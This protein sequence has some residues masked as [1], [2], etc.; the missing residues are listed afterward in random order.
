ML[1]ANVLLQIT[2]LYFLAR[3][4]RGGRRLRGARRWS[5]SACCRSWRRSTSSSRST[6][7][8]RPSWCGAA[9]AAPSRSCW[10]WWRPATTSC[11]RTPASSSRCRPR[12]SCCSRCSSTQR[13]SACSC[14]CWASTSCRGWSSPCA[15]A[16]WRCRRSTSTAIWRRSSAG[17]TPASKASP[18]TRPRPARPR[19]RRCRP[20]WRS[21]STSASRSAW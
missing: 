13:R 21:T 18:P 12:C 7:A 2:W 17:A 19:S 10:P 5:C 3:G 6:T 8:T 9:C 20:S 14:M 4:R 1:A 15:T 16:C 11:P